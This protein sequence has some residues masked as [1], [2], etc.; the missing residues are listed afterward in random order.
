MLRP[1]QQQRTQVS[2]LVLA[3][4]LNAHLETLQAARTHW[5]QPAKLTASVPST[6]ALP[7]V[8]LLTTPNAQLP[9]N[10]AKV[11]CAQYVPP[12]ARQLARPPTNL[13]THQPEL[14]KTSLVTLRLILTLPRLASAPN[15][16]VLPLVASVL[17]EHANSVTPQ[18]AS[19]VPP[20][21]AATISTE[22]LNRSASQISAP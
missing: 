2:Q 13:V 5:S 11:E 22:E 7:Q 6:L 19:I 10:S 12:L 15:P 4:Q 20:D 18:A 9:V 21:T 17:L 16:C 8:K 14:A 1:L 3:T